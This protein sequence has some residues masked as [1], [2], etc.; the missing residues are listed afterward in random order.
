VTGAMEKEPLYHQTARG[1]FGIPA[2]W[3]GAP[4]VA[5][6]YVFVT[7]GWLPDLVTPPPA[8]PA[9]LAAPLRWFVGLLLGVALMSV[10]Q[11]IL[12]L[13]RSKAH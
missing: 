8:L 13:R 10:V 7:P 12:W 5:F 4:F 6:V 2:W 1:R 11:L 9:N 3:F